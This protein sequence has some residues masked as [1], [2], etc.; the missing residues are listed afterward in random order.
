[1]KVLH[2]QLTS[3]SERYYENI[4]M[5]LTKMTTRLDSQVKNA[6]IELQKLSENRGFMKMI[7]NLE[8]IMQRYITQKTNTQVVG[9]ELVE[10]V[11]KSKHLIDLA[12]QIY[13]EESE[14]QIYGRQIQK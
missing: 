11:Q 2:D 1:M 4:E 10:Y 7:Q 9:K 5:P 12:Q 3:I 8:Q 6:R 14:K 13:T